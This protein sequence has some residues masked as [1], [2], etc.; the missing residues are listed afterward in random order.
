M[1]RAAIA[2]AGVLVISLAG[3]ICAGA[4]DFPT[5]PLRMLVGFAPGGG[6]D[7]LARAVNGRLGEA[8]GEPVIVDNRPGAGG[9]IATGIIAKA[10]P[11][12][13]T[14]LL[15]SLGSLAINPTLYSNLP[16]DISRDLAPITK[17]TDATNIVCLHPSVPASNIRELI[18][19][20][21]AKS[22]NGGSS[23]IGSAGHM[24][25]QLFN[26]M[27]G[28][29]IVHVPYKSGGLVMVDLVAGNIQVVFSNPAAAMAHIRAGR[30][31][32]IAVTTAKRA[33]V[34]PDL[35]TVAESGVPGFEANNWTGFLVPAGTPRDRIDRLNKELVAILRSPELH[36]FFFKLA[37]EPNPG[38]PEQF[39]SYIRSET[40]KWAAVI[41]A[42]GAKGE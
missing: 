12:G 4:A 38:T 18:A 33:Q 31:K 24:S 36:D 25:L 27:A 22:H 7:I 40:R 2:F 30:V 11:D 8:L 41:K 34:L 19:H 5:K 17:A 32:A 29:K 13:H 1:K 23:G 20:A 39:A 21:K 16:F 37:L 14:L 35:P 9:N 42:S 3:P 26:S 6:A 15:G 28:T 10:D